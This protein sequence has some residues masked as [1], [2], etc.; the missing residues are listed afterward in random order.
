MRQPGKRTIRRI[1]HLA[2]GGT[3]ASTRTGQGIAPTVGAEALLGQ[4]GEIARR[5]RAESRQLLNADSTNLGPEHW[6]RIAAAAFEG[7]RGFDGVVITHGTH[8]LAYTAAALSLMLR[9]PDRPVVLTGAQLPVD[10]PDS[11]AA[12]NLVDAF[13]VAGQPAAGVM[14]VFGGRILRADRV[15]KLD[16]RDPDAFRSVN[17]P[18][19]GKVRDGRVQWFQGPPRAV[20]G[21]PA[22]LPAVSREV[23]LLKLF[24]SL[25][26]GIFAFLAGTDI[27]GVVIE[28]YGVGIIP[29]ED[30][31]FLAGV[32]GLLAKG[33]CVVLSTQSPFGGTDL[34]SYTVGRR[35]LELGA[36]EGGDLSPEALVVRLMWALGQSSDPEKVRRI[37]ASG[38]LDSG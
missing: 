15:L 36:V 1:L 30:E 4:I 29:F 37:A 10:D 35:C 6:G 13:A 27:K 33:V 9:N 19:L 18:D 25:D 14:V 11:D 31:R 2:T 20:P 38:S 34:G 26:P 12:R 7:L 17:V 8:T 32:E 28:G 23:F 3:I 16:T 22:L 5:Y 21:S 24:P